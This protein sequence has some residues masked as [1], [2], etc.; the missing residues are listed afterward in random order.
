MQ[1]CRILFSSAFAWQ[2]TGEQTAADSKRSKA[3]RNSCSSCAQANLDENICAS[4]C[5]M[6]ASR[7]ASNA[8]CSGLHTMKV[9]A[10]VPR[11]A[12]SESQCNVAGILD[13]Q[14]ASEWVVMIKLG[15][16]DRRPGT[17]GP[18]PPL[19][20]PAS[21][22]TCRFSAGEIVMSVFVLSAALY[23]VLSTHKLAFSFFLILQGERLSTRIARA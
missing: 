11:D 16:S 20:L 18:L 6:K 5:C 14:R 1:F 17:G 12:P 9:S 8:A 7:H 4:L 22:R 15:A 10:L 13:T 21:A 19:P 3:F 2:R 23:G